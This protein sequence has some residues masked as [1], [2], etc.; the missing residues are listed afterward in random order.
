MSKEELPLGGVELTPIVTLDTLNL[1]AEL[2]S[3]KRKELGD[4]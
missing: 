4:S 1:V 2:T 3:D